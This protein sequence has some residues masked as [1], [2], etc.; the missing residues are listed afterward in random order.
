MGRAKAEMME[1]DARGWWALDTHVCSDCVEDGHLKSLIEDNCEATACDYCG[2]ESDEPIAAPTSVIQEAI[3]SAVFYYFNDPTDAGVPWDEGA[4]VIEPTYTA[5]VLWFVDLECQDDLFKDIERSFTN[6]AWV[7]AA[8][9]HWTSS[10]PHEDL[11]YSWDKFVQVV[12]HETRYFFG[13]Q[14]AA[15]RGEFPPA[16]LLRR[17]GKLVEE[18]ALVSTLPAGMTLYR[19]RERK[20]ND[21]WEVNAQELGPP[22]PDK[23]SAGRMNPAGISYF[24]LAEELETAFAEVLSGPPCE[25]SYAKFKLRQDLKVI[26]LCE[27]EVPSV[28]DENNRE[29]REGLLFIEHFVSAISEPVRK[30]G[31]EH[32]DYVPSQVVSEFFAKVFRSTAGDEIHGLVYPSAVQRGAHNVVIFPPRNPEHGWLTMVEF[33]SGNTVTY[34]TWADFAKAIEPRE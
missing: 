25:T 26:D 9:G 31:R 28:F 22:P 8:G 2:R 3:A 19:V 33:V 4:P 23:A 24:Y 20:H 18:S 7:R 16:Q 29:V 10:H 17:I 5:D 12:K 15:E 14:K 27:F 6:S 1:A 34:S 30:D 32:V 13:G 21:K 11:S